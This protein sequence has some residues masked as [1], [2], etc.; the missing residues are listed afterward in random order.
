MNM[1]KASP[2]TVATTIQALRHHEVLSV[3]TAEGMKDPDNNRVEAYL[4]E[5]GD[6]FVER[7]MNGVYTYGVI[8]QQDLDNLHWYL[9]EGRSIMDILDAVNLTGEL[10]PFRPSEYEGRV[11]AIVLKQSGGHDQ[12][13]NQWYEWVMV[14]GLDPVGWVR[15]CWGSAA[16]A[17]TWIAE[18]GTEDLCNYQFVPEHSFIRSP[19]LSGTLRPVTEVQ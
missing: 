7:C 17:R 13:E 4:V 5:D 14:D 12:H 10:P 9:A 1:S 18:Y 11:N 16:L 3:R 15:V 2:E 8:E 19:I 6:Y